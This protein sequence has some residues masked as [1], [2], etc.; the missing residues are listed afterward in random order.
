M[1]RYVKRCKDFNPRPREEGDAS[2]VGYNPQSDDF[3]PR[4]REEGDS[5]DGVFTMWEIL[6]SIHALV[7]R[8]TLHTLARCQMWE[9]SIHALVKRATK[10]T[11][12]KSQAV[13]ISIH[14]LVKRATFETTVFD[15]Q[16]F[17]ISIHA[18]VKRATTDIVLSCQTSP[19]FNP[20]PREEGDFA[21][22]VRWQ[23]E[24]TFQSTPS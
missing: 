5:G 12:S 23:Y 10:T 11:C 19:H 8:A 2:S 22:L 21:V 20:R 14:A 3:N 6:I 18:L 24:A 4:P 7:K 16:T 17:T 1:R 13:K 15:G 9:I